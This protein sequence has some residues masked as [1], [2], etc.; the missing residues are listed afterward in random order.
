MK[1]ILILSV[2]ALA[3]VSW[4]FAD[5]AQVMPARIGR[6]YIAPVHAFADGGFD[7]DWIYRPYANGSGSLNAF[8]LGFAL[9]YGVTDWISAAIQWAPGITIASTVDQQVPYLKTGSGAP[10]MTFSKSPVDANGLADMFIGAKVLLWGDKAP[11]Q[12]DK[13]RFALATGLKVP[14]PGHDFK[15]EYKNAQKGDPV[16]AVNG[17]NHTLGIGARAYFDFVISDNFYLNLYGEYIGYPIKKDVKDA[18]YGEYFAYMAS[19][20]GINQASLTMTGN[21]KWVK[22]EIK[23]QYG[24][25]L[26]FEIEPVFSFSPAE[27]MLLSAGLP[28]NFHMNPGKTYDITFKKITEEAYRPAFE[29]NLK[30]AGGGNPSASFMTNP[31]V[32]AF[33]YGWKMPI[34]FKLQYG[35]PIVGQNSAAAHQLVLQIKAY[36]QI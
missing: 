9:E 28:F 32:S 2:V 29:K 10:V 33:M 31:N 13:F 6:L 19:R 36:F 4:A 7:S 22:P 21:Q 35:L 5:N 11:L 1:K 25:D 24:Y 12:S 17:G 30:A 14:M 15:Q 20:E 27:G 18:S 23:V 26:T 16:T 3:L 34:E 8:N